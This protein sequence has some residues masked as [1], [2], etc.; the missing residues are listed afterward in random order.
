ME[1]L[2]GIVR[3][4]VAAQLAEIRHLGPALICACVHESGHAVVGWLVGDRLL[5]DVVVNDGGGGA[6][7]RESVIAD[8]GN[9]D[10]LLRARVERA[11]VSTYAGPEAGS[12]FGPVPCFGDLRLIDKLAV[13]G[14]FDHADLVRLRETARWAVH[15]GWPLIEQVALWLQRERRLEGPALERF[16]AAR[17]H[18]CEYPNLAPFPR[19]R[20]LPVAARPTP[21]A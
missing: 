8:V 13:Y 5:L 7:R 6:T 9:D 15:D 19:R 12:R 2:E 3:R 17:G 4:A 10:A 16:L 11:V 20:E 1:P 21:V 18:R 14:Q